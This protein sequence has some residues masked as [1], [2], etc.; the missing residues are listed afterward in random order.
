M[1][2]YIKKPVQIEAFRFGIDYMPD[3]FMDKV[4]DNTVILHNLGKLYPQEGYCEI[5]MLEGTMIGNIGDYIIKGVQDEI[6]PCKEE[7]FKETYR[8]VFK[9]KF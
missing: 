6:Y 9:D 1:A 4:T 3:W 8:P 7:I 5:K 2:Q